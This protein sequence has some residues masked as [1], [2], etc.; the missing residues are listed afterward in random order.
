[1]E[2]RLLLMTLLKR[3]EK[4]MIFPRC[5]FP[6]KSETISHINANPAK[7][8]LCEGRYDFRLAG[9]VH[10]IKRND[11]ARITISAI[12]VIVLNLRVSICSFQTVVSGM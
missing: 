8:I 5:I 4:L 2:I 9:L 3:K 10:I 1:M 7:K 6:F 11:I 12:N